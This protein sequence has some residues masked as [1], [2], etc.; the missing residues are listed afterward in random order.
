MIVGHVEARAGIQ[1]AATIFRDEA[2]VFIGNGI[3]GSLQTQFVDM[4]LD[5]HTLSLVLGLRE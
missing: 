4:L 3:V 5:A 1:S 2:V